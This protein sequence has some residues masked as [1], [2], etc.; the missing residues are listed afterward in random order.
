MV[1]ETL[2]ISPKRI[3]VQYRFLNESKDD[4]QATLAFPMPSYGWN[5]GYAAIASN[6]RP[7]RSFIAKA[8]GQLI[9]TSMLRQAQSYGRDITAD[10][11]KLGLSERQIFQTFGDTRPEDDGQSRIQ[12]KA[13]ADLVKSKNATWQVAETM[14]WERVFPARREVLVEHEYDPFAGMVFTV[15]YQPGAFSEANGLIPSTDRGSDKDPAEAC[16]QEGAQR[17]VDRRV[18]TL[19]SAT[20]LDS[21]N[22]VTVTLNDVEYVLGTG[23]NWR[24][25]IGD[26]KLVIEKESPDQIVSLCFPGKA[27]R[28][29]PTTL[30]FRQSNFVPQDRLVVYFYGVVAP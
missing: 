2:Y 16:V 22:S 8:D 14:V 19:F 24:G 26:F 25:P 5:P 28:T 21:P 30:E 3:R 27:R 4:V 23:R 1:Q 7:M 17:A 13:I 29:S 11:R 9:A 6:E 18:R 12:R 10:L 20:G 15:L